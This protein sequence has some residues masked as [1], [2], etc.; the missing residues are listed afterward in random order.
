[1]SDPFIGEIKM[2]GFNFAPR[3]YA[4]CDGSILAI[5]PNTALFS[6]LGTMYG[7]NGTTNF[8]LPDLRGR[9]PVGMGTGPGLSTIV[10][11]ELSG[12]ENVTILSNQMPMHTHTAQA[13]IQ[14]PAVA[15][16]T[17]VQ[18][19]PAETTLL[20]P[21]T[22]GGRPGAMYSTD[23]AST[24]LAPFN[25]PVTVAPAGG[26]QPLPIR[27]PYLGTNFIIATEGIFPSRS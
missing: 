7:G 5:S 13:S 10:Q 17:N 23:A 18:A 12:T 22:A 14:I 9:A 21:V 11:G 27:N 24:T 26:S 25:N 3:G 19:A 1:M 6:L 2:V 8:G 20:G 16:S 15:A 4:F